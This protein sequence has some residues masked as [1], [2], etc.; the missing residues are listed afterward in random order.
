MRPTSTRGLRDTTVA[1]SSSLFFTTIIQD[2]HP[3]EQE[4]FFGV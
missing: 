2:Q 3:V 1:C 4:V